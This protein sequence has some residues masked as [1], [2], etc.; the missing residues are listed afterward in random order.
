[1]K[2]VLFFLLSSTLILGA[3]GNDD[4]KA[5]K[6]SKSKQET[7]KTNEDKKQQTASKEKQTEEQ[8]TESNTI[9]QPSVEQQ[10]N[11]PLTKDE[12]SQRMRNGEN[13]NGMVDADGDTWYQAPGNGDVVGYT[14]P[15][16][17]QC[18]VGGCVTPEQQKAQEEA[19]YKEMEKQGYSREEYDE[20]QRQAAELQQQRD[21]GQITSQEFTDRY[22]ELYD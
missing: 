14:K 12:I 11:R 16:G 1:M 9:E 2:K 3:C 15:D 18:T 5:S 10:T 21:N 8:P 20:I 22:L 7:K 19:N 13:V 6:E 4:D 17:T